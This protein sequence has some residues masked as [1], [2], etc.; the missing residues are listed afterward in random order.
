MILLPLNRE[1][2]QL[3]LTSEDS[4]LITKVRAAKEYTPTVEELQNQLG[5]DRAPDMAPEHVSD[6]RQGELY[7]P[8]DKMAPKF[9]KI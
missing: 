6:V 9:R 3:R 8:D 2:G 4:A 5:L 1:G 7:A